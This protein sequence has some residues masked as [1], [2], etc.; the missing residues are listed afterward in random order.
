MV[1]YSSVDNSRVGEAVGRI[2]ERRKLRTAVKSILMF[3]T[4]RVCDYTSFRSILR[5]SS[6]VNAEGNI[7]G[8]RTETEINKNSTVMSHKETI[9]RLERRVLLD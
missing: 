5:S 2:I 4:T 8:T 1:M 9:E 3:S 6:G 7:T